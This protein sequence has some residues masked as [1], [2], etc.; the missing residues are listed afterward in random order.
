MATHPLHIHPDHQRKLEAIAA[1]EHCSPEFILHDVL[2]EFY[3][4]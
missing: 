1:E 3:P 2:L 4:A